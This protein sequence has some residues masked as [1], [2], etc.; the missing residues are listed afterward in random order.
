MDPIERTVTS[1]EYQ[2][3][4]MKYM[5]LFLWGLFLLGGSLLGGSLL[6]GSLVS[7]VVAQ[8]FP[9]YSFPIDETRQEFLKPNAFIPVQRPLDSEN[10]LSLE[11]Q[12]PHFLMFR[13]KPL[14]VTLI[15]NNNSDEPSPALHSAVVEIWDGSQARDSFQLH[16]RSAVT[17]SE[18][19]SMDVSASN[20][21]TQK[22]FWYGEYPAQPDKTKEWGI[23][24]TLKTKVVVEGFGEMGLTALIHYVPSIASVVGVQQVFIEKSDLV[25][26]LE[27][28]VKEA[29]LYKV[30]ANVFSE[31]GRPIA[32]L[33]QR[34]RLQLPGGVI[35]L[36]ICVEVLKHKKAM[37]SY[38]L[39]DILIT[40]LPQ[41]LGGPK[42]YGEASSQSVTIPAFDFSQ[43]PEPE[44]P[45]EKGKVRKLNLKKLFP[46]MDPP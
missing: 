1:D 20:D 38:L 31:K 39:E 44:C 21:S 27:F 17:D 26:P 28:S 10:R 8:T 6:G 33:T 5:R 9:R 42:A 46:Q 45:Q 22:V 35:P 25:V 23:E 16:P 36:K 24:L 3:V 7:E 4:F 29:G 2:G 32:H 15:L 11:L 13:E 40:R 30:S 12:V 14:P 41:K 37:G 43:Y 19:N 34:Q 18:G